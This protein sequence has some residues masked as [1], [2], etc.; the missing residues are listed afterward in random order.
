MALCDGNNVCARRAFPSGP[1]PWQP[2]CRNEQ[3]EGGGRRRGGLRITIER[4]QWA[5][6]VLGGFLELSRG[7]S[8]HGAPWAPADAAFAENHRCDRSYCGR[9]CQTLTTDRTLLSF[10]RGTHYS[11]QEL[12]THD[13]T[14]ALRQVFCAPMGV[15]VALRTPEVGLFRLRKWA[16]E[17]C[18]RPLRGRPKYLYASYASCRF[19]SP[20]SH[21]IYAGSVQEARRLN[22]ERRDG[23]WGRRTD[24]GTTPSVGRKPRRRTTV[25]HDSLRVR[26][27]QTSRRWRLQ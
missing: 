7:V 8:A 20:E 16:V 27:R 3:G 4:A 5:R 1:S 25:P 22:A 21:C 13:L 10:R 19:Y 6:F 18:P 9:W 23:C 14:Q 12:R 15:I 17:N 24:K 2:Q 26:R 11:R